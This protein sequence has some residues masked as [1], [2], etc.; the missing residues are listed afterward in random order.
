LATSAKWYPANLSHEDRE[1]HANTLQ[2]AF[3]SELCLTIPRLPG[4]DQYMAALDSEA[5][6]KAT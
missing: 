4:I 3:N 1:E 6:A 2:R 5:K